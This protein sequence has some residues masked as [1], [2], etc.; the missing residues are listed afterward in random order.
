VLAVSNICLF[1]SQ[2]W[3]NR[4]QWVAV[5]AVVATVAVIRLTP[6]S[7]TARRPLEFCTAFNIAC[8][9]TLLRSGYRYKVVPHHHSREYSAP[10]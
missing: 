7:P 1:V 10:R 3:Q 9:Y 8:G 2:G 5:V 6:F 4:V